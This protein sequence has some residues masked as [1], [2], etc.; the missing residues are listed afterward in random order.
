M[1]VFD[2]RGRVSTAPMGVMPGRGLLGGVDAAHLWRRGDAAGF[3]DGGL[4]VGE[5]GG[6]VQAAGGA[7]EGDLVQAPEF[8][9]DGAPGASGAAFGDADQ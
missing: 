3:E 5:A 4:F 2:R 8:A 6:L 1:G 9:V 7:G